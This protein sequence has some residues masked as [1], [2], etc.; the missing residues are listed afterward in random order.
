[1]RSK[2]GPKTILCGGRLVAWEFAP[3]AGEFLRPPGIVTHT[4][5]SQKRDAHKH[6]YWCVLVMVVVVG[7]SCNGRNESIILSA[8]GVGDQPK[9]NQR[10]GG[11]W[12][13]WDQQKPRKH[14]LSL[15]L[16]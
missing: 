12:K 11:N 13:L 8:P 5:S 10:G 7:V 4:Q 14:S 6:M 3:D 9:K 1:M 16:S 15:C 2:S